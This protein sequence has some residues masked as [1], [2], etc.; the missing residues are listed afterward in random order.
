MAF[1]IARFKW[2]DLFRTNGARAMG[3]FRVGLIAIALALAIPLVS[4]SMTSAISIPREQVPLRIA[5]LHGPVPVS[6]ILLHRWTPTGTRAAPL[7][8]SGNVTMFPIGADYR[9]TND[10]TPQNE[11]SVAINPRSGYNLRASANDYRGYPGLPGDW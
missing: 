6:G 9:A 10:P 4:A 3:G 2:S 5:I 7:D 1:V 11:V 8:V